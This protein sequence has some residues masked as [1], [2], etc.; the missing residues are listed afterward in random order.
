VLLSPLLALSGPKTELNELRG[1][2]EALQKRLAQS[3][4]SRTEA[5]DALRES[6]RAISS[7]NRRLFDLGGQ[8]KVVR[9]QL[10]QLEA[11]RAELDRNVKRQRSLLARQLYQRYLAGEPEP[12]RL[13]LDRQ[14]PSDLAR[15][16]H[17][18]GYVYR[19]R[20]RTIEQLRHDMTRL[21]ELARRS[22]ERS[23]ALAA[24]QAAQMQQRRELE[25]QKREHAAVLAKVSAEVDR[26]R[27]EIGRLKR[28]EQRLTR[29]VEQLAKELAKKRKAARRAPKAAGKSAGPLRNEAVP[30][31][32]EPV[33]GDAEGAFR[34]LKGHMRL[35]VAGE[36]S[37]RF[38]GPREG[39]GVA[40]KGLFIRAKAGEEV[41][42]VA[43]GR[44]VFSDWL[45]GFGNL[46]IL[47]HE[48]GFMSLYAN[49][50]A[51]YRQVGDAVRTGDPIA[52]VGNSGGSPE[53]GLYFEFRYQG[54]PFD[55]LSWVSLKK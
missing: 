37:N 52:S 26:E 54:R 43:P 17:Y 39:G 24:L 3:E 47:D 1:R 45:R 36:L 46:V 18:L 41:H 8:Q 27:K 5:T 21:E 48:G 53:T 23:Q 35:P 50:E 34:D 31:A 29:L 10:A 38:G 16:M 28:D 22:A 44:V 13:L 12:L 2:I 19:A 15:Q 42:A 33:F 55:P 11:Q 32:G 6:E 40:W 7:T 49:N 20:A 4:G 25:E 14:D 51:V 30:Q 9:E